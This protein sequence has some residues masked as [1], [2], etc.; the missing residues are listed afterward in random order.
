[1]AFD[2]LTSSQRA[3]LIP[4]I[5]A[6]LTGKYSEEFFLYR[7][8]GVQRGEITLTLKLGERL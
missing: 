2:D 3:A 5:E 1:M 6:L 8:A 4:L 7:Q